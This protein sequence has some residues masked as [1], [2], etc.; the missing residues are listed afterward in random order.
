MSHTK[1]W[2]RRKDHTPSPS[3]TWS[4]VN[5][6]SLV[7]ISWD[8]RRTESV[9][10]EH[11]EGARH[12]V[13]VASAAL[14]HGPPRDPGPRAGGRRAEGRGAPCWSRSGQPEASRQDTFHPR[15]KVGAGSISG[16]FF[17]ESGMFQIKKGVEQLGAHVAWVC[18]F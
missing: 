16:H 8:C 7:P 12:P 6:E 10:A 11:C 2:S 14:P 9:Q 13:P 4:S 3:C 18:S 17:K 1:L 5:Q 15:D